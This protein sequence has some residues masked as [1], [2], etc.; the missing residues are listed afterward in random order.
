[1]G[2]L[3]Y[4]TYFAPVCQYAN[5]LGPQRHLSEVIFKIANGSDGGN[6]ELPIVDLGYARY[7]ATAFNKTGQ[8]YNFSNIR[9]AAPPLGNLRWRNPAPSFGR[10]GSQRWFCWV[11]MSSS[12]PFR[13]LQC[14]IATGSAL[15]SSWQLWSKQSEDCL[16]LDVITPKMLLGPA[17]SQ[18]KRSTKLAPVLVNIHGGGFFEGDKTAIYWPGG[19]LERGGNGFVYVSMNY[20]VSRTP[21]YLSFDG[22]QRSHSKAFCVRLSLRT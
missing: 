6:N 12:H 15:H 9:Y 2:Q 19:L 13:L 8:Y 5:N 16:F 4:L 11:H 22:R 1:M 17:R 3:S 14:G 20:R 18:K 21:I 7:R 10:K